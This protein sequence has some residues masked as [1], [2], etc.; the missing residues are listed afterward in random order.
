MKFIHISDLHLG[1][2]LYGYS[3]IDNKDQVHWVDEFIKLVEEEQ[4]DAVLVAGDVYD[5]SIAPKEAIRLFDYL[6]TSLVKLNIEVCIIA[7]NHD[8]GSRLAFAEQLLCH[9][10][11]Y[12]AG[13][14]TKEIKKVTLY[15]EFGPVQFWLIPYLFPAAAQVVLERED[16]KDYEDAMRALLMQQDFNFTE[17]NVIVAHQ[18]VVAGAEKPMMGG[19]ETTVGGIGQIDAGIFKEF[20]Y[21]ALGHI[22]NA[23]RMGGEHI[24]YAGS[25]LT[26]HFSESGQKKG[27]TVVDLKEKGTLEVRVEEISMLHKMR[28]ISGTMEEIL[29]AEVEKNCYIRAVIQQELLPP[30][31]VELLRKYFES[32]ECVLMEV[33]RDFSVAGKKHSEMKT[34]D[35]QNLSL[36][37]LFTEFYR[38]MHQGEL[39]EEQFSKLIS[40]TAEQSRNNVD[41][42]DQERK[43]ATKQLVEYAVH[44]KNEEEPT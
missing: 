9:Q 10:G 2:Y 15:D 26:Y 7:G 35:V 33:V 13:E 3:M 6:V 28:E 41:E 40:F 42:T 19:S 16:L 30:Q 17:R 24:R 27:L 36:E 37:E 14:I 21:V 34:K 18:F 20:D 5:R 38:H 8:S 29:K 23:Q 31:A 12:I 25:P 4:V 1:K 39:P 44:L 22:H 43:E 32:K 11:I